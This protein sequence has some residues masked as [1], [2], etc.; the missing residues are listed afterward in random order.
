MDAEDALFILY[1]SGSTGRPKGVLHTIGGYMVYTATVFKY[2]FDYHSEDVFFCTA[3]IGWIT[4]HTFNVYGSLANCATIVL[5]DGSPNCPTPGRFW[6]IVER[7]KVSIFYTAPTAI[8]LLMKFGDQ[9]VNDC[10]LSSLRLLGSVGEPLNPE[11]W[12]WYNRVVGKNQCPICDT[13][14]QSET[15]APVITPIPGCTD[16]KPG[17][18]TKPFFGI[19][20]A[21]LNDEGQEISGSGEGHLVF[22]QAWPGVMRTVDGDHDRFE[23]T[24]FRKF[25]GYYTTGD[26]AYRDSSGYY[27]ITGRIDDLL[28]VSG[29]LLSTAE[30]E[31]A[32][33]ENGAIAEA[34]A[35]SAP[36]AVKGESLYCF[37]VLKDGY[38]YTMELSNVL[39]QLVR[40]K[41]GSFAVPDTLHP[42]AGLPKT[43]SGK[44]MRRILRKFVRKDSDLGDLSTLADPTVIREL[45]SARA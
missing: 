36:H 9:H 20:P 16:L 37:I 24:Y 25:P 13:Y 11:A 34:A 5:F 39:K 18:A 35:V 21:I 31:S 14:W 17:S 40:A 44:I 1:T 10:D 8:R 33:V 12:H 7:Y 26:G 29:H 42:V 3:D 43:R 22:K 32:L 28:N 30:I 19:V 27:F 38:Q 4:G 41:I 15:G 2:V 6:Q 45:Y 23:E